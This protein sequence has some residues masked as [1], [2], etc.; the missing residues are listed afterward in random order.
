VIPEYL[1]LTN[2]DAVCH[3][4]AS[5]PIVRA[6]AFAARAAHSDTTAYRFVTA[7]VMTGLLD[8]RSE[9]PAVLRMVHELEHPTLQAPA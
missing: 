4:S 6:S 8:H 5:E 9:W 1:T 2:I 7:L 3:L